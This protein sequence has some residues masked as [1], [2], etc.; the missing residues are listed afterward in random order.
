M[1]EIYIH[2]PIRLNEL[3][4]D[5]LSTGTPLPFS[6]SYLRKCCCLKL[7]LCSGYSVAK[8]GNSDML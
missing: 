5:H 6:L 4:L 3:M 1:V 2:S 8:A 7:L